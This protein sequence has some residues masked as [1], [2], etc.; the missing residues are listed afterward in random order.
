M[1]FSSDGFPS[2]TLFT[3]L[4]KLLNFM[5]MK[6][7]PHRLTPSSKPL[8]VLK[9]GGTSVGSMETV[10]RVVEIVCQAVETHR[11][12]VTVSAL[13][14]VTDRLVDLTNGDANKPGHLDHLHDRHRVLAEAVLSPFSFA[15]YEQMLTDY[16]SSLRSLL[17]R[18]TVDPGR[19]HDAVLATGERL[20]APLIAFALE[21]AGLDAAAHDAAPLVR[22]DDRH[23]DASV[24]HATTHHLIQSWHALLASTSVPVVTG[25]LGSSSKGHTTTL[26]RGGSDYS[27]ALFASALNASILE[28]W[29]DVDGL[30]TQ[31]PHLHPDAEPLTHLDLTDAN[32][33]NRANLLGMHHEALA[34]LVAA[35]IPLHVRSTL[36]AGRGTMIMPEGHRAPCA[37]SP[38]L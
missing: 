6:Y 14:G 16:L 13:S 12:V 17:D 29:T 11:I 33:L 35:G 27:A 21:D 10:C 31:D 1:P 24:D 20:S 19:R 30:Y 22:T 28:R 34:P 15:A 32:S 25:F 5:K 26:G 37:V 4:F 9:F 8:K 2:P 3:S 38:R 18:N 7:P 23:G 36:H